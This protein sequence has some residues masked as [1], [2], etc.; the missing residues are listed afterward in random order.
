MARRLVVGGV[1][2]D[3]VFKEIKNVHLSV[4]PPSG[5]VRI[6]APSRMKL[7]TIRVFAISRLSWI[8]RQRKKLQEQEREPRRQYVDRESHWVWGTRYLLEVAERDQPPIIKLRR[9]RI[10]LGVRAGANTAMKDEIVSRWYRELVKSAAN[11]LV[12]KWESILGV[13]AKG[14]LVR[15]MKT[16][17]GSCNP[18][19]RTIR[20]NTEL[21][22]KPP[23]CLEYIVVH[24]MIHVREPK[25]GAAFVTLMDR[26]LPG[27]EIRRQT[28]NRLPIRHAD[29]DY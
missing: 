10:I 17:W 23:E 8:R 16:K 21:G 6:S 14:V 4:Y 5:R 19:T 15:R 12:A 28:L 11:E 22:K 26:F 2:V 29:W 18:G 25:H 9:H 24:E 3:V 7:D 20:L 1:P 27:W 13:E